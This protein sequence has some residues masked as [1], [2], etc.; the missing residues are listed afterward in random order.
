MKKIFVLITGALLGTGVFAQ[1][2]ITAYMLAS[3]PESIKKD[4]DVVK[5][6]ENIFFEVTDIDRAVLKKHTVYTIFSPKGK[7]LLWFSVPTDKFRTL[8]DVDIKVYDA[9]GK[10]VQKYKRKDLASVAWGDGLIDDGKR[11]YIQVPV[12]GY[13][14]TVEYDY[15][16]RY[17]GTLHYPEYQILS[18]GQG[19]ELS[20][21]TA[22][23]PKNLDLRF[24]P[25][26]IEIKPEINEDDKYRTYRWAVKNL[27]PVKSEV[28][29]IGYDDNLPVVV[30]A[31]NRFKMDEYEGDMSTWKSFGMW[32]A[33][34]KKG[35]DV[36]PENKKAF[37][38]QLVQDAK[39]DREKVKIIYEYLKK[40][41]RYVSI[42]LG[43]GGY[44]PL[45]AV[46]TDDKKYG[47]CKG[48]S[49][50]VQ[51]ALEAVNIKSYQALI[52]RDR[53]MR[54]VENDFPINEFNHVI[55]MVPDKKDTIWLECTSRTLDFDR[56]DFSTQN[57]LALVVTE[58]GGVLVP[59]PVTTS[60]ENIFS[61][62]TAIELQENGRGNT[63]SL[64]T[65][66]GEYNET[67]L[68]LMMAKK[69]EQKEFLV[70]YW[71]IKQPDVFTLKKTGQENPMQVSLDME[72]EKVPEF[73]AGNKLFLAPRFFKL[74]YWKIPEAANRKKD[75]FLGLPCNKKDTS[76]FK[77]PAGFVVDA[78]PKNKE[79]VCPY[80][81]YTTKFW[82]NE[83]ENA[84][85]SA[86]QL[87]IKQYRV[88]AAAYND[89]KK[90][91]DE[92]LLEDAQRIVIK[93]Q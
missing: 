82:F 79:L 69:D 24:K 44:K 41:F 46:F 18:S 90:F 64:L 68:E 36:L 31:P 25:K 88:P 14:V 35:I 32:Y 52:Y 61:V 30:L 75:Y 78:L 20:T 16:I 51:A 59:T 8:G 34:M 42:S 86:T 84:V 77:L 2:P 76:V 1:I 22:K 60:D 23:V 85:Y 89:I 55:L 65:T 62:R 93:K 83:Q 28:S 13:P 57:R 39:D 71:E 38:R 49:N 7:D 47:D 6:Y 29:T 87:I 17:K 15:E 43:I 45:P 5:R 72:V 73:T 33:A 21:F 4:A 53:N 12:S 58:E 37:F 63:N 40:N 11:F 66:S 70:R 56:L 67:M 92:V 91:F 27:S 50:Y 80:A 74:S 3:V 26:N 9:L 19:L 81:T 10:A 48:L 54:A